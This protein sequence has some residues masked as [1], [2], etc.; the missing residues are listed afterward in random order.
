MTKVAIDAEPLSL[1]SLSTDSFLVNWT[2]AV[3]IYGGAKLTCYSSA[4]QRI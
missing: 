3:V 2:H 4:Y 1:I